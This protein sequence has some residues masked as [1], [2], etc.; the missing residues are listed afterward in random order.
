MESWGTG[1]LGRNPLGEP[2]TLKGATF[3]RALAQ[4]RLAGV[5]V[6]F[7]RSNLLNITLPFVPDLRVP[8]NV[9]S[10]GIRWSFLN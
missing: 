1:V 10:F 2:V 5:I 9:Y 8:A 6:Y 3:F 7:D 4:L